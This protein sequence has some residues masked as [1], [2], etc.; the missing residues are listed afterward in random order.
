MKPNQYRKICIECLNIFILIMRSRHRKRPY[1]CKVCRENNA[2]SFVVCSNC[3]K[4]LHIINFY[5]KTRKLPRFFC[6]NECRYAYM[7]GES[8]PNHNNK[9]AVWQKNRM[10]KQRK[11]LPSKL[12]GLTLDERY[13]KEKA[14]AIKLSNSMSHIGKLVGELNPSKRLDVRLKIKQKNTG[15]TKSK[16]AKDKLSKAKIKLYSEGKLIAWNK[17][18]TIATDP[19]IKSPSEETRKKQSEKGKGRK[20]SEGF[21]VKIS[22]RNKKLWQDPVYVS[23]MMSKNPVFCN[24][25]PEL[26]MKELLNS[27]NIKYEH[28]IRM[29]ISHS[30][31][32]DFYLPDYN[33]IIE[34]D[35]DL[36]HAHPDKFKPDDIIP[37]SNE[38]VKDRWDLDASRTK[39]LQE[40][41][42]KVL[43]LWECDINKMS[44]DEFKKI[45]EG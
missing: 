28:N 36:F 34:C 22:E 13:G 15:K 40:K 38:L 26:K 23:K 44:V 8:N 10:S 29:Y 41:G 14:K 20:M 42:Y 35:G 1:V 21:S 30:Y 16:E 5:I 19:R 24:T 11:G 12:K 17:G 31:L 6:S 43:R 7:V 18:L 9:W 37:L 25:E 32:C 2:K 33:C 45:L 4:I 3:S 39:E 27:L